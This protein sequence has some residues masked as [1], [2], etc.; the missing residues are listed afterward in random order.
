M[1][2]IRHCT[3]C[4]D[5]YAY[6]HKA[7][8][9]ASTN[10]CGGCTKRHAKETTK[11]LMLQAAG[12]GCKNCGYSKCLTAITFYDPI[13][14]FAPVPDP[15]NREEKIKWASARIPLCL[16]CAQEFENR[17]IHLHMKDVNARPVDCAFYTDVA[18]IVETPHK[19]FA[20]TLPDPNAPT[21]VDVEI[22][23]DEPSI[24]R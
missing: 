1:S 12:G 21:R 15:K 7:K 22:T 6:D 9:G 19:K 2:D 8:K 23:K 10:R 13:A 17:M 14:R 11:R 3:D 18:D 4:G 5:T 20:L 16:N 24:T